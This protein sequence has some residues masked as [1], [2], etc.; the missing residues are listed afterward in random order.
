M[1]AK[2]RESLAAEVWRPI[3]DLI[4]RTAPERD[5]FIRR[6]GLSVAESRALASLDPGRGRPMQV[7]AREW[8]CDPS[9]ATWL[10]DRLERQ[11]LAARETVAAD[12]RVKSVVLTPKGVRLRARLILAFYKPP[13]ELATLSREDLESLRRASAKLPKQVRL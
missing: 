9:N 13:H 6:L 5:N 3:F 4:V 2:S 1:A 12:R 11:G 8:G 7:L 10:V